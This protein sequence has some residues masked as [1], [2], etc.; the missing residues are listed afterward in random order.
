MKSIYL[1]I[2]A[3]AGAVLFAGA[4]PAFAS[5]C[6]SDC[7]TSYTAC[8]SANGINGQ[9]VCTPKW[10]QCKKACSAPL[11][12]KAPVK[13]APAKVKLVATSKVTKVASVTV[14]KH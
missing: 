5:V 6:T 14:K 13:T 9:G 4:A 3:I 1:A 10:M 8:N 11:V 2:A 12:T 7:N